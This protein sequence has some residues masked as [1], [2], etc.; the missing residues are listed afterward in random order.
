MSTK[1]FAV[2][3]LVLFLVLGIIILIKHMNKNCIPT[4]TCTGTDC[5]IGSD[6][7]GGACTC[8]NYSNLC[9]NGKCYNP[10]IKNMFIAVGKSYTISDKQ[11]TSTMAKSTDGTN[12]V[13]IPNIGDSFSKYASGVAC[14]G[15]IWVAVGLSDTFSIAW[16]PDAQT[17]VNSDNSLNI[18]FSKGGKR[19]ACNENIWVAVGIGNYSIATSDDGKYWTGVKDSNNILSEGNGIV[20]NEKLKLWIAVGGGYDYS[21]ATSPDGTTWTG[22]KNSL[23]I[24]INVNSIA[25][26]E[27]LCIV[28]GEPKVTQNTIA[29]SSDGITWTPVKNSSDIFSYGNDV[30]WNGKL[31]AAVGVGNNLVATSNDGKTWT[32]VNITGDSLKSIAS[33][34]K[35]W[36]IS[37]SDT[38]VWTDDLK[39]LTLIPNI[40]T[41]GLLGITWWSGN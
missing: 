34:G 36:I 19:V 9:K 20:W 8:P 25:C 40:L 2:L 21:I 41:N 24:F 30:A 39:N 35:S 16:S 13:S 32:S 31:W 29:W 4:T 3:F 5:S 17:W 38:I 22:V 33:N 28:V 15:L 26:N 18:I 7:C 12:W 14:N 37:S 27:K 11:I 23:D 10:L 6:G 1:Y